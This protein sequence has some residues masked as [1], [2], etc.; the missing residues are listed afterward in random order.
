MPIFFIFEISLYAV[1]CYYS[2]LKSFYSEKE[3]I[4]YSDECF[5]MPL[6]AS[7][8][9]EERL[10]ETRVKCTLNSQCIHYSKC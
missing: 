5:K 9:L 2:Q 3:K 7:V 4:R 6:R 8:I 1:Q 10:M